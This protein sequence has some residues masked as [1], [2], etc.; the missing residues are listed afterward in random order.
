MCFCPFLLNPLLV[1]CFCV[2]VSLCFLLLT[3]LLSFLVFHFF[4]F[5]PHMKFYIWF[6]A[7]LILLL[8]F[9]LHL[10]FFLVA[11]FFLSTF[12]LV[13]S[14]LYL[15]LHQSCPLLMYWLFLFFLIV[16]LLFLFHYHGFPTSF[17]FFSP[18]LSSWL[19]TPPTWH[20]PKK[21]LKPDV[22][23]ADKTGPGLANFTKKKKTYFKGS[24]ALC[25]RVQTKFWKILFV[26]DSE[27]YFY[28][29]WHTHIHFQRPYNQPIKKGTTQ[30]ENPIL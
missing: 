28:E 20:P 29:H 13:F 18:S 4:S 19:C 3:P 8:F 5:V 12:V 25:C 26:K 16:F 15:V 14:L 2:F 10:V 9:S 6:F 22:V 30:P 11:C 17:S 27:T 1:F 23:F 21:T 24:I 7:F